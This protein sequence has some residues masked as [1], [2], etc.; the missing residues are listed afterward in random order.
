[1]LLLFIGGAGARKPA[2]VSPNGNC[3]FNALSTAIVANESLANEFRVRTCVEMSNFRQF[4]EA[5]HRETG[6]K[7]VSPDYEQ[8]FRDCALDGAFSS[9]WTIQAA[10]TVLKRDIVSIYPALNGV[11]DRCVAILNT[12]FQPRTKPTGRPIYIMWSSTYYPKP[13]KTWTPN[14][15]VPLLIDPDEVCI[16]IYWQIIAS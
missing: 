5:K 16:Y 6:L 2:W 8:A 15:F 4:Y 10:S 7:L 14:H 13:K 11:L 3:L 12:T 1:M 9:A